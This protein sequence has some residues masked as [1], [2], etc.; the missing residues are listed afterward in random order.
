MEFKDAFKR[1]ADLKTK[2]IRAVSKLN[3]TLLPDYE[4][5]MTRWFNGQPIVDR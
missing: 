1:L 3:Q 5:V 4:N 2:Y